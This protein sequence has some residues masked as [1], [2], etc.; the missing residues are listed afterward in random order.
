M[1]RL[2][3]EADDNDGWYDEDAVAEAVLD[4]ALGSAA[5]VHHISRRF[6]NILSL[7]LSLVSAPRVV[8]YVVAFSRPCAL[9]IIGTAAGSDAENRWRWLPVA[10]A[11]SGIR[12]RARLCL[13]PRRGFIDFDEGEKYICKGRARAGEMLR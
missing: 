9:Y 11:P 8:V 1:Y 7:S 12:L 13:P 3:G 10:N 5:Q 2:T 6:Y 4:R